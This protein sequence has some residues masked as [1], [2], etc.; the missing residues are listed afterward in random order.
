MENMRQN[1][2]LNLPSLKFAEYL[3]KSNDREDRQVQSIPDQ[4]NVL[5]PLIS[6]LGLNIKKEFA[7]SKSAKTPG[8]RKY[9]AQMIEMI[10]KGE[11]NA[12][13][14][15][16]VNR[17]ARN[18]Q[19]GGILQQLLQDGKLKV[20][21]TP[22]KHYIPTENQLL[23]AV[24]LGMAN[25]YSLDLSI[26][27]KRGLD[28]KAGRGIFPVAEKSGYKFY[29]KNP[30]VEE[31]RLEPDE[32]R[33]PLLQRAMKMIASGQESPACLLDILNNE[34]GYRSRRRKKQG[35]KP[36]QRSQY[37]EILKDTFY[38]G[39]FEYPE[40]SGNWIKG[41]HEPMITQEEYDRIQM[42][43]GRK[44]RP[45]PSK[46]ILPYTGS[47]KCGECGCS[48]TGVV[49]WQVICT[50]CKH[51]F[52]SRNATACPECNTDI[53]DMDKP[54]VLHYI[55]YHCTK[56]KEKCTQG[57]IE[58]TKLEEQV[59]KFLTG[60]RVSKRFQEW[61]IKCLNEENKREVSNRN[62]TIVSLHEA[63]K[64]CVKRLDN[65][66]S[67][68]ISPQNSDG[69][70]LSDQRYLEE[71]RQLEKEKSSLEQSMGGVGN[72]IGEWIK[73][74]ERGFDFARRANYW[75][76]HGTIDDQRAIFRALGLNLV[77]KDKELRIMAPS[78]FLLM[79]EACL[80]DPSIIE[81]VEPEKTAI[82]QEETANLERLWDRSPTLSSGLE[83][84]QH[85]R[86]L[87]TRASTALPPLGTRIVL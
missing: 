42:V 85:K 71:K 10:E 87:Q 43:L 6:E 5:L 74:V 62:H 44:G 80:S 72:R 81:A 46:H 25:Q 56:K 58:V 68:K 73:A 66:L 78:L 28:E 61:A 57:T 83:S 45:R 49:Q 54:T 76:E 18:P 7:E 33:F 67:L 32:V 60:V 23:M 27:V 22:F 3:R 50:A 63:Y 53:S 37:Y 13:V 35:G 19:E 36:M 70:L 48:I 55:R 75:I 64:D 52:S 4:R 8:K 59:K 15:W 39:E 17:L 41:V 40:R 24:E 38:Y 20:V 69:E 29:S 2:I 1:E 86:V 30:E 79:Q 11:I 9:F 16:K 34:W 65:L 77:L 21:V 84:N 51:K 31:K 26:D 47:M 82:Q 12:I 14:C